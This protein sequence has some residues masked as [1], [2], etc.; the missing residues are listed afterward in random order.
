VRIPTSLRPRRLIA[1]VT[2]TLLLSC[3]GAAAGSTTSFADGDQPYISTTVPVPAGCIVLGRAWSGNKTYLVQRRLGT[4][5]DLDRYGQATYEAVKAFQAH[6][7]LPVTGRV[8]RTT[9]QRLGI[10]RPFCMDRFTVQPQVGASARTHERIAA[11]IAWAKLQLGRRY[12][13]GGAGPIGYDCSGLSLQALHAG[14]RVLP[15]VTTTLHQR[16]DFGTATAIYTSGLLR[17]PLADRQRGDLVFYG[18]A[19]SMTH[20]A[21]YLGHDRVLEAVRPRVRISSMWGKGV[22]LKPLVV[23]PF[24]R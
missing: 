6:H 4:M 21:I 10:G 19:G 22:P 14:G 15:T 12:I 1:A 23:R 5:S 2:A 9:W 11:M 8:D 13:W 16:Q 17:L 24:G 7:G 18:P 3:L 20:M